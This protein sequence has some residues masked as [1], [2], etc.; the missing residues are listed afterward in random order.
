MMK[1]QRLGELAEQLGEIRN[2][3]QQHLGAVA[4]QLGET[5]VELLVQPPEE[6]KIDRS[7]RLLK[8]RAFTI[9]AVVLCLGIVGLVLYRAVV[10]TAEE[11]RLAY[12]VLGFTLGAVLTKL[13]A[14]K[15]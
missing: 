12:G 5:R 14:P 11:Q 9:V 6:G 3:D 13:A 4:E 15:G 10:G 7:I 8:A 1:Q 2:Q